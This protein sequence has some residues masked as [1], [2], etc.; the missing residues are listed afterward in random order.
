MEGTVVIRGVLQ[1]VHGQ[2]QQDRGRIGEVDGPGHAHEEAGAAGTDRFIEAADGPET[3]LRREEAQ[4]EIVRG[5]GVE[6][7]VAA[8]AVQA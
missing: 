5:A 1:A 6:I 7:A 4:I 3:V 2:G 8:V